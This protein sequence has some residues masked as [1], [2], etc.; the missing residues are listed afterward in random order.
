MTENEGLELESSS[1]EIGQ[2]REALLAQPDRLILKATMLPAEVPA[3]ALE[4]NEKGGEFV[5]QSLGIMYAAFPADEL[6]FKLAEEF[7]YHVGLRGGTTFLI[8]RPPSASRAETWAFVTEGKLP[9]AHALM[10]EI[11]RRFDPNRTLNPGR[12]LGGI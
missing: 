9:E 10:R 5:V 4:V 6:S 12:F 2:A 8:A 1:N 11:K 7:R 3:F